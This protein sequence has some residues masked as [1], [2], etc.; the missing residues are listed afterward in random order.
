MAKPHILKLRFLTTLAAATLILAGIGILN[1]NRS[2]ERQVPNPSPTP[3]LVPEVQSTNVVIT[4]IIGEETIHSSTGEYM[5]EQ[6][7]LAQLTKV[8]EDKSFKLETEE[9]QYGIYIESL[10]GC[11]GDDGKFWLYYINDEPAQV[12]ASE[13]IIQE[14]DNIKWKCEEP[15]M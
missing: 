9:S 13:Y 4:L 14:G 8:S 12:G 5:P 15:K 6:T 11:G 2:L 3:T 7:A 10:A 1:A